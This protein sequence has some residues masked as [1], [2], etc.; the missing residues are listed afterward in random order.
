MSKFKWIAVI[1]FITVLG[2]APIGLMFL[3]CWNT[4][5]TPMLNLVG[6]LMGPEGGDKILLGSFKF[7]GKDESSLTLQLDLG[8][9]NTGGP[10]MLFPAVNLSF[11]YGSSHLGE[12]W[13]SEAVFIPA[14][15][16]NVT[17][18]IY[19]HMLKG[20]AFNQFFM[21][22]I[23]GGLS[24]SMSSGEAFVFLDT[25]G[26]KPLG[27]ISI[28]LPPIP[29]PS[30]ALTT[31]QYPPS[32]GGIYRG[33]VANMTPVEVRAN[34][35]DRG[36]GVKEVILSWTNGTGWVNTTMMGL[37]QKDLMG[38]DQSFL[39]SVFNALFPLYP[40]N[41]IP[42]SW[43]PAE[44][45]GLIPGHSNGT[46]VQYRFYVIDVYNYTTLVPM[47]IPTNQSGDLDTIDLNSH[48]FQ[49]TVP[50]GIR[51]NY[52]ATWGGG[53]GDGGAEA[54]PDMMSD[55]L[56]SLEDAGVDLIS[57][58][59]SSS[60]LLSGFTDLKIDLTDIEGSVG[61]LFELF[62]PL[63]EF[64]DS[65]GVDPF[66]MLDQLLGFSGGMPGLPEI[67]Q[68][69]RDINW[70][71][72]ANDTIGLDLLLES[73]VSLLDLMSYLAVNMT[74]LVDSLGISLVL[75]IAGYEDKTPAEAF[76]FLLNETRNDPQ[77]LADFIDLLIENDANFMNFPLQIYKYNSTDYAVIAYSESAIPLGGVSGDSFYIGAPLEE[78][79]IAGEYSASE[80][81][82][83]LINMSAAVNSLGDGY[84]Y[85][86]EYFNGTQWKEIP[87]WEYFNGTRWIMNETAVSQVANFTQSGRIKFMLPE[88]MGTLLF[89]ENITY[90]VRVNVS[91]VG[92]TSPVANSIQY[93]RNIME[94]Y[95]NSKN[96]D[97]LGRPYAHI[98]PGETDSLINMLF[99]ANASNGY[100][101]KLLSILGLRGITTE[102]VL[103]EFE[104]VSFTVPPPI[105]GDQILASSMLPM[106]FIIYAMVL[107]VVV[108]SVRGRKGAYAISPI[109][110]KKWYD[111]AVMTPS[112]KTRE[113]M[114]KLKQIK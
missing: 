4:K 16:T 102:D 63:I 103:G 76:Y 43:A 97:L 74:K 35:S 1:Y 61:G 5:L 79:L 94:Y 46:V 12:G 64:L 67:I 62:L 19:A 33:D 90:W 32:C 50:A 84:I 30:I 21:S 80:F 2:I 36:G 38:G 23:G 25:F 113:E 55:I 10:D 87:Q 105:T 68:K 81:D 69:P 110:V 107:L 7:V 24:L 89:A 26:G 22:L 96:E 54:E 9:N 111:Q 112:L 77:K 44:V 100:T 106:V 59:F 82:S 56:D 27:V 104:V 101:M 47:T 8:I 40:N 39:G 72:N 51:E 83:V 13:I 11:N 109:R 88:S 6:T 29:L 41:T 92:D 95:Y 48:F 65:K 52:T 114:D 70:S 91:A 85:V 98:I 42:T 3:P 60:A 86:W 37:P 49:Y 14:D 99:A 17:I 93:S 73:G 28:P 75:P 108:A 18:P 58:L 78:G 66:E 15:S 53:G 31:P 57:L 34:V 45:I 20:D 71:I